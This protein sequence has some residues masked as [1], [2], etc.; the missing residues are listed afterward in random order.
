MLGKKT[1][2]P[3]TPP[4]MP[5]I[6]IS[7]NGPSPIWL[8]IRLPNA[9]TNHSIPIIGYSPSTKVPSN[10]IY[11]KRKKMGYPHT[12]C[13]TMASRTFVIC[14]FSWWLSINVSFNA[15]LIKPYFA[16]VIADSLSSFNATMIRFAALSRIRI[17]S[18][19]LGNVRII[20]STSG[21]FSKS[22]I[23]R[24]R[25]EYLERMASFFEISS[26][27]ASM[28]F[29]KSGPWLMWIW[30]NTRSPDLWGWT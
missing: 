5:S 1:I 9:S 17:I 26:F 4:I 2:T 25:V 27:T 28:A 24:K 18:S 29:S 12:R 20:R 3:P 21:S 19:E 15:P 14:A 16:S 6:N 23:A 11:M 13:V 30:R 7:F 10:M 22:F 8:L